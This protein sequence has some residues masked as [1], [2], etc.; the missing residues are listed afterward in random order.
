MYENEANT[1][2][3]GGSWYSGVSHREVAGGAKQRFP[4]CCCSCWRFSP[5][6]EFQS[7]FGCYFGNAFYFDD[8]CSVWFL[9]F[10][11]A[12][13]EP[14]DVAR[15]ERVSKSRDRCLALPDD[16]SKDDQLKDTKND[17]D[18]CIGNFDHF[19]RCVRQ[20]SVRN[21]CREQ[22]SHWKTRRGFQIGSYIWGRAL[23]WKNHGVLKYEVKTENSDTE[24]VSNK[25]RS[26]YVN[27]TLS[28]SERGRETKRR[29][30]EWA[31]HISQPRYFIGWLSNG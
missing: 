26:L 29:E 18:K 19:H 3:S 1:H 28:E 15:R 24:V 12:F 27:R 30:R 16:V 25:W 9:K 17:S 22:F 21:E 4:R 23:T 10:L 11:V 6:F 7:G 5:T 13:F 8:T 2:T 31:W 20:E 14:N